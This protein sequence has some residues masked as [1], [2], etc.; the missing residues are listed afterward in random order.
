MN[1]SATKKLG[2]FKS[3][4]YAKVDNK[5]TVRNKLFSMIFQCSN[6]FHDVIEPKMKYADQM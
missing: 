2:E 3:K 1:K 4:Q 5:E 6:L